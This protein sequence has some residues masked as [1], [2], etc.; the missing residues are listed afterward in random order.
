[1][2]WAKRVLGV[3]LRDHYGQT[4]TGMLVNNHHGLEHAIKPACA[5][6]GI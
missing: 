5:A 3:S 2:R 1:V 6:T 4:E